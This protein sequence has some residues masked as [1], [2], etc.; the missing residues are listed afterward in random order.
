MVIR[1]TICMITDDPE[2]PMNLDKVP[3]QRTI[4]EIKVPE[5]TDKK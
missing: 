4:I 3:L 2:F 5:I 1:P